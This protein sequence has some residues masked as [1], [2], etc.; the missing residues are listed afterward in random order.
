MALKLYNIPFEATE[1][2]LRAVLQSHGQVQSCRLEMNRRNRL[3]NRGQATVKFTNASD[4]QRLLDMQDKPFVM[5]RQL[6]ISLA[7]QDRR[8]RLPNGKF[9]IENFAIGSW[10]EETVRGADAW[11]FERHWE[12]SGDTPRPQLEIDTSFHSLC[13]TK[14]HLENSRILN[15]SC[16]ELHIAFHDLA[17]RPRGVVIDDRSI[18][19]TLIIYLFFLRPPKIFRGPTLLDILAQMNLSY[20]S[21]EPEPIRTIDPTRLRL[22]DGRHLVWQ[23]TFNVGLNPDLW[24]MLESLSRHQLVAYPPTTYNVRVV[25]PATRLPSVD[26]SYFDNLPYNVAFKIHGLLSN[27]ILYHS[28]VSNPIFLKV[29]ENAIEAGDAMQA[30]N[31]LDSL[32]TI[33]WNP[34]KFGDLRPYRRLAKMLKDNSLLSLFVPLPPND[35]FV[36]INHATVT[37]TRIYIEGPMIE[38]SN[39]VLR[40]FSEHTDRF[41][42]V[43]FADENFELLRTQRESNELLEQR[44]RRVLEDG[45]ITAGRRHEFLA[46][47]SSQ[48]KEHSCWFFASC[49][50]KTADQIREWMGEF[51]KIKT[52]ALYAARMGQCFTATTG[53]IEIPSSQRIQIPDIERPIPGTDKNYCFTDG[54]GKISLSL[55]GRAVAASGMKLDPD[56]LPSVYQ[57]RYGGCKGVVVIDRSL[58]GDQLCIRRS[59]TKFEAPTSETF[60]IVKTSAKPQRAYLNRQIIMLLSALGTNDDIFL[61]LQDEV[62]AKANLMMTD[63]DA[64]GDF[65]KLR[66]TDTHHAKLTVAMLRNGLLNEK[67][68]FLCA[69]LEAIRLNT[70]QNL[71]KKA[72]ILVEKSY[73]LFGTVDETC[74]LGE[75]E[76]FVQAPILEFVD[77][78]EPPSKRSMKVLEGYVVVMRNPSLHPGDIR[79]LKAV[80]CE[81]L[82][83]NKMK[84]CVVFSSRGKRPVPNMMSGGD[85]GELR[86]IHISHNV[87]L[88]DDRFCRKAVI[89]IIYLFCGSLPDGDEYF[90]CYDERLFPTRTESPMDYIAPERP[91]VESVDMSHV[92]KFFVDYIENDKLGMIANMHMALADCNG[93]FDQRCLTLCEAHSAAVDFPKTGIPAIIGKFCRVESYPDFMDARPHQKRHK[94]ERILGKLYRRVT[95]VHPSD[96]NIWLNYL[97]GV[98]LDETLLEDGFD[99]YLDD[100]ENCKRLYDRELRDLMSKY[101]IKTEAEVITTYILDFRS[102]HRRKLYDVQDLV[103]ESIKTLVH[104]YRKVFAQE[105]YFEQDFDP[106]F[107]L[108][109]CPEAKKKASAWYYITYREG[110]H[111]SDEDQQSRRNRKLL[112]F[113]WLAFD[114]LLKIRYA[115]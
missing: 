105:I 95:G 58:D 109:V 106:R 76:V 75:D 80:Q 32:T 98:W 27:N 53:T 6:R 18:P 99:D 57:M 100:A 78:F 45:I 31:A 94:S 16:H 68:P 13:I 50:E 114:V 38:P 63:A 37:P 25:E 52:P 108:Q 12:L 34:G 8:S 91:V 42:R 11:T 47:G 61:Q 46:F 97:N 7:P 65:L 64:A 111:E 33:D 84:N 36:P 28:E 102:I 72:R 90:V 4:A 49:P 83:L 20:T 104:K 81:P 21:D 54:I 60:E 74:T 3:Q 110:D 112:S 44:V 89:N 101:K 96:N 35:N 39:R 70:L 22:F 59:M 26:P 24:N 73:L 79:I 5:N 15:T 14:L 62:I 115:R 71:K 67:E 107:T 9:V 40:K 103:A 69:I 113:A 92:K 56:D 86:V 66:P 77:P 48:L 93:V 55:A 51:S 30:C 2:Q 87:N 19:G 43:N 23:L 41:L 17:D 29:L 1:A 10:V 85:L 82:S 88:R